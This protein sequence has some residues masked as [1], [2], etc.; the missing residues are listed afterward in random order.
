M[1]DPKKIPQMECIR[2]SNRMALTHRL[3]VCHP[4]CWQHCTAGRHRIIVAAGGQQTF[5]IPWAIA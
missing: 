1:I 5:M 2:F 3:G 4:S